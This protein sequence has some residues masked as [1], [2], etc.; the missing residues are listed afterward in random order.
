[1]PQTPMQSQ[2]YDRDFNLWIDDTVAKLKAYQFDQLDLENLIEEIEALARRD[3]R[4][5]RSRLRVLLSHLLKR[6]YVS[7]PDNFRGWEI[8]I[9][10]QRTELRDLLRQSPSLRN[11]FVE[12]F[13]EIWQ[14]VLLEVEED[15]AATEFPDACPFPYDVDALLSE[16]FWEG[17]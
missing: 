9:R 17:D 8:T 16:R 15:Y 3:K 2:L 5:M 10:D 6:G 12:A 13:D 11:Y 14:D 7:S 4:E 1:M